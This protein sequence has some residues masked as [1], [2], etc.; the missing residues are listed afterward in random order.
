MPGSTALKWVTVR[1]LKVVA[2]AAFCTLGR[3]APAQHHSLSP[4]NHALLISVD[5]GAAIVRA[6][7]AAQNQYQHQPDCSHLVHDIYS[8]SGLAY[9]FASS[10]DIFAG[11]PEFSRVAI[12]QRGDLIAWRGHVGIVMDPGRHTFYSSLR[13]GLATSY[14]DSLYWR[15]RGRTRFYRYRMARA[16]SAPKATTQGA[17]SALLSSGDGDTRASICKDD[18]PRRQEI[19]NRNR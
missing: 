4:R 5:G 9:K 7:W 6:V 13:S 11:I 8:R 12:P 2:V 14:F 18:W 15:R 3:T 19:C 17:A 10:S 16:D 1:T